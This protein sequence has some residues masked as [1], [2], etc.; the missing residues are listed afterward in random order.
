[1]IRFAPVYKPTLWGSRRF[2]TEFGRRVPDGAIGESWE[3]VDIDGEESR[4]ARGPLEGKALGELWRAGALGGTAQGQFPFLL[5]WIDTRQKL[6][7]QV[8][9]DEAACAKLGKGHPKSE[10]WYVAEVDASSV[11]LLGHYPGL[12]AATLRQAATGGT[13]GKWLYELRPRVGDML[14][15]RAGTLHAIGPGLLLLEVQQPSAT[16]FRVY[17]WGR[18]D[19]SGKPRELHVDEACA[20]VDFARTGIPRAERDGV[21]GPGFSMRPLRVGVELAPEMLRV[22]V[23]DS[24]PARLTH[25]RGDERLEYGDVV[26]AEPADGPVQLASG[27]ALLVSE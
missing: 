4:V 23:A 16:T 15:V 17:D 19:A 6:S 14:P 27:T 9:P 18:T 11:I 10:A 13:I 22:F 25:A 3:L 12:D 5:K 20:S 8:H 24:G 1:M 26:V 2:A 7:V 21:V